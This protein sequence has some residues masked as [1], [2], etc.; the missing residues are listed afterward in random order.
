MLAIHVSVRVFAS[1]RRFR[2]MVTMGTAPVKVLHYYHY[3]TLQVAVCQVPQ[4]TQ[5]ADELPGFHAER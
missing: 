4:K 2:A 5:R 3:V 1:S